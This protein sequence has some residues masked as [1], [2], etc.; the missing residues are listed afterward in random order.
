MARQASWSIVL[1]TLGPV[2]IILVLGIST[3]ASQYDPVKQ[4]CV[5]TEWLKLCIVGWVG[6]CVLL[7]LISLVLFWRTTGEAANKEFSPVAFV[8]MFGIIVSTSDVL[9]VLS[10]WLDTAAGRGMV[11]FAVTS[12]YLWS[13]GVTAGPSLWHAVRGDTKYVEL[14]EEQQSIVQID[15]HDGMRMAYAQE[16]WLLVADFLDYCND[17]DRPV[18]D[19]GGGATA[20]PMHSV[21]AFKAMEKWIYGDNA[22]TVFPG[23]VFHPHDGGKENAVKLCKRYLQK[24]SRWYIFCGDERASEALGKSSAGRADAFEGILAWIIEDLDAHYGFGYINT[25]IFARDMLRRNMGVVVILREMREEC[26]Q[27]RFEQASLRIHVTVESDHSGADLDASIDDD[28]TAGE[29]TT[30]AFELDDV[31]T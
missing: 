14:V 25:D 29:D 3:G 12:M 13:V 26:A 1:A 19:R 7:L 2:W 10:G 27:E 9:V 28:I 4:E 17:A 18:M 22:P 6:M 31:R 24:S 21:A 23:A 15:I 11:T 5:S 8:T 20:D 16:C 30:D